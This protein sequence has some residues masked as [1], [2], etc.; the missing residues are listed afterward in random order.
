MPRS[1]VNTLRGQSPR[2]LPPV[3]ARL[4]P[5]PFQRRL[6]LMQRT[7]GTEKV[8]KTDP[9]P[10][11]VGSRWQQQ[12]GYTAHLKVCPFQQGG[13]AAHLKVCPF[14]QGNY[15][16]YLKVCPFKQ[17]GYAAHLKVCPFQQGGYAAHLKVCPFKQGGYAARLKV[18]PFQQGGYAAR[19]KAALQTRRL[20]GT[21][22]GVPFQNAPR[23]DFFRSLREAAESCH[24]PVESRYLRPSSERNR[25]L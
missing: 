20:Y 1:W 22:E 14:K 23:S 12:G 25:R 11:K 9:S 2:F 3:A 10:T 21:P 4:K 24:L 18:C 15:T 19:L 8:R 7:C 17:G 6:E 5:V 13:Y 16:A